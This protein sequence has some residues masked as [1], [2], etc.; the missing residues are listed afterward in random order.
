MG[1]GPAV[2]T[3]KGGVPP[4]GAQRARARGRN[5]IIAGIAVFVIGVLTFL[6]ELPIFW[7]GGLLFGGLLIYSGYKDLRRAETFAGP[8]PGSVPPPPSDAFGVRT[9]KCDRCGTVNVA[10]SRFCGRC[11]QSLGP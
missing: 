4:P 2:T 11:G 3:I 6:L 5:K 1:G 8:P 7:W 10:G 9:I